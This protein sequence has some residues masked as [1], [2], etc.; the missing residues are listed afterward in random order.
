MVSHHYPVVDDLTI[1]W[2]LHS[3]PP[4]TRN[5]LEVGAGDGELAEHLRGQGFEVRAIDPRGGV[6]GVEE[7][8]LI[9]LDCPDESFDAAIA[10]L[11]LHHVEPLDESLARLARAIRPGGLLLVD[12]FDVERFDRA[13]A[14]WLLARWREQ[15]REVHGDAGSFTADT[16][17]HLHPVELLHERLGAAGFDV[18]EVTRRPY[19]YRW[20]LEPG[21]LDA[22][23]EL[24]TSGELPETGARFTA[25]RK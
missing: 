2:V 12:E 6:P 4:G 3:L 7:V 8:A 13:A 23:A 20:H 5:V 16:R 18:G 10:M 15:G 14:N 1:E 21:L 25:V 22:E 19:L 17:A 9:D 11:S 24:I